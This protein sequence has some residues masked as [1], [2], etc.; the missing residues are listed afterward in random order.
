MKCERSELFH[1]AELARVRGISSGR[2]ALSEEENRIT[3]TLRQLCMKK[4]APLAGRREK[5][6]GQEVAESPGM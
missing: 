5:W 1:A 6:G 3:A 2:C 4:L